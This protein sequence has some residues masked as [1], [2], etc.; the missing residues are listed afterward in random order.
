M[1]VKINGCSNCPFSYKDFD[2]YAVGKD[3]VETCLLS[4]HFN[5][6]EYIIGVYDMNDYY[7]NQEEI[8]TDGDFVDG[9]PDW[10]L[11]KTEEYKFIYQ[12]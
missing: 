5:K 3:T 2:D 4:Q 12:K 10:C 9:S 11:L 1:E 7:D 6:S 8:E